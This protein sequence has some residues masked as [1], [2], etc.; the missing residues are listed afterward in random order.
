MG[1]FVTAGGGVTEGAV[2][3]T[4]TT[5]VLVEG[6]HAASRARQIKQTRIFFIY[7]PISV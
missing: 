7:D 3:F 2:V 1:V 6:A 5:G 4:I